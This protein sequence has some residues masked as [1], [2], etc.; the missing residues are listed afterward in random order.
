[1]PFI[2]TTVELRGK[3]I[4]CRTLY[5]VG[6]V[7]G[8]EERRIMFLVFFFLFLLFLIYIFFVCVTSSK[9]ETWGSNFLR[10]FGSFFFSLS[11]P[12]NNTNTHESTH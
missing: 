6:R 5:I 8:V 1:M 3:K 12:R 9:G 4:P 10:K 7:A 2:I 11:L